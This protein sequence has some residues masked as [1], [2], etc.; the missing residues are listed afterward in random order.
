MKLLTTNGNSIGMVYYDDDRCFGRAIA[1]FIQKRN[2][3]KSRKKELH[4]YYLE[5]C[6]TVNDARALASALV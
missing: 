2:G 3:K 6:V 1:I 5:L 4:E